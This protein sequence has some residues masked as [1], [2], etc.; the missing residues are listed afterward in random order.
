[1][2]VSFL[3]FVDVDVVAAGV[4]DH[5]LGAADDVE[6]AFA[7]EASEIAGMEPSVAQ[8]RVGRGLIVVVTR[9]HVG[10]ASENLTDVRT[11]L[12]S[13]FDLD[14]WN[15]L[16]HRSRPH[17][18]VGTGG[19]EHGRAFGESVAFEQTD[20]YVVEEFGDSFG[21]SRAAA[22]GEPEPAAHRIVGRAKQHAAKI[23]LQALIESAIEIAQLVEGGVEEDAA[24]LDF[25]DDA[26]MDRLPERGHADK[27]GRAHGGKRARQAGGIDAERIDDGRAARRAA[28]A[29]RT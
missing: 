9:H 15:R 21:E 27:R 16:A 28:A 26:A 22:D 11:I 8:H 23:K 25:V 20:A 19:G 13:Q 18:L 5:F 14:S 24:M 1:M 2:A 7:V 3:E 4:D 17:R 10:S 29:S 6:I 12:E